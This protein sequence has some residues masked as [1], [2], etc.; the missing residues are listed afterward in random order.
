MDYRV[1]ILSEEAPDQRYVL[2]TE[3]RFSAEEAAVFARKIGAARQPRVLRVDEVPT[4]TRRYAHFDAARG[5][6][7]C[8][9]LIESYVADPEDVDWEDVQNALEEALRAFGLPP[10]YP[11]EEHA[12]RNGEEDDES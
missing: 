11:E 5:R 4:D 3:R 7:A 12:R 10:D 9:R 2:A 8:I 6:E 1:W